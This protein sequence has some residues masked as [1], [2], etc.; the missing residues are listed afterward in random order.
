MAT[1][2]Y[3]TDP[4][5]AAWMAKHFGMEFTEGFWP[6]NDIAMI[7]W[8]NKLVTAEEF[9]IHPDSLNLLKPQIGDIIDS[10]AIQGNVSRENMQLA[11]ELIENGGGQIIQRNGTPFMWPEVEHGH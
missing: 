8:A 1:K 2:Y 3:Y 6:S 7:R 11:I 4:L 5:A 10:G 9:Y